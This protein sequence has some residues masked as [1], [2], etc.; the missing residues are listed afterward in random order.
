MRCF[1][2]LGWSFMRLPPNLGH[3]VGPHM[4]LTISGPDGWADRIV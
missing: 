1:S 2:I 3:M 4:S